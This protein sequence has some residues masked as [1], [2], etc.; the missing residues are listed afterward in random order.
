MTID[1]DNA[2][3][4]CRP[5]GPFSNF[6]RYD[7]LYLHLDLINEL[8]D[9]AITTSSKNAEP[10]TTRTGEAPSHQTP[11]K[12]QQSATLKPS[13]P[14]QSPATCRRSPKEP[15]LRLFDPAVLAGLRRQVEALGRSND[16]RAVIDLLD[17]GLGRFEDGVVPLARVPRNLAA[18]L[19]RLR[20]E[21]PNFASTLDHL[22]PLLELQRAGDGTVRLPPLLLD[23]PP[24]IGKTYF[25]QRFAQALGLH[26]RAHGLE[27][28]TAHWIL[29]GANL[30]WQS[31]GPGLVLRT[32]T[33]A[34]QANPMILLDEVDKADPDYRH[35]PLKALYALLEPHSARTFRD[36]AVPDLVL[37]A[38]A[39]NWML[40]SNDSSRV[41]APLLSRMR[42]VEVPVP[43]AKQRRQI[44]TVVYRNLRAS[45]RWGRRFSP[46]LKPRTIDALA[47]LDES[48][49]QLQ[50]V[51]MQACAVA[52]TARRR[53][54]EPQDVAAVMR[55]PLMELENM[56]PQGNA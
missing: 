7:R 6:R 56:S 36:E 9:E 52:L 31:G 37:D 18:R 55:G 32:L 28:A 46:T 8:V 42:R 21:M 33:S 49:R 48:V 39:I 2:G 50:R 1:D 13:V 14:S 15:G 16:R 44:V 30:T 25:A 10:R 54:I 43:N 35:S 41:P 12:A 51:L 34:G 27:A 20:E 24:G 5:I 47:T 22:T 11:K 23:G 3:R 29:S 45:H 40:T 26:F 38:S 53:E 17:T 4:M 19:T